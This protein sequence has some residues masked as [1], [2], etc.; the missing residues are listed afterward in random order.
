MEAVLYG[1]VSMNVLVLDLGVSN[2][3]SLTS[4]LTY[5]G[6]SHLVSDDPAMLGAATHVILPGVGAFDPAMAMIGER[7]LADP[8]RAYV[9]DSKRPLLGVCLGMQLLCAGSDEGSLP[10]LGLMPGRFVKLESYPGSP[11]K[12]P[13]V[14]FSPVYG[15]RETGLF[16]GLGPQSH[17]YFTHS[18][19]LPPIEPDGNAA[20]C[21]H[22]RPF[23]AGFQR[24][25]ICG[26]QFHPEKSQSAGLRLISNFLEATAA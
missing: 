11:Q 21:D 22:A 8:L 1:R 19:A 12:V 16:K 17:F 24:E 20:L 6:A 15:Y 2:I 10:G 3:R 18:Y 25:N 5:L 23:V 7:S 26:V 14:G 4:A 9:N 13:H